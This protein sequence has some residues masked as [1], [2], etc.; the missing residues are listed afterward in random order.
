MA[1]SRRTLGRPEILQ[2]PRCAE[3]FHSNANLLRSQSSMDLFKPRAFVE[4]LLELPVLESDIHKVT[5]AEKKLTC[6]VT[7]F[8]SIERR[9]SPAVSHP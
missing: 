2:G 8:D 6:L 9:N 1:S 5:H 4:F 3:R 7:F